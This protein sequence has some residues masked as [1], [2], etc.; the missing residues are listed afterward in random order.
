M[1]IFR[2]PRIRMGLHA[3]VHSEHDINHSRPDGRT[4]YSGDT[5]VM[6]RAVAQAAQGGTVLLSEETY[7][8]LPLERL[9]DKYLVRE[10]SEDYRWGL[11]GPPLAV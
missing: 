1:L 9:W 5:V 11:V 10:R 6:G 8:K 7:K 3:G 4:T 2:G